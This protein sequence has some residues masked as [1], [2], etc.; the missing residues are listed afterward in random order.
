MPPYG[1]RV[2]GKPAIQEANTNSFSD[3]TNIKFNWLGE[4]RIVAIG[5]MAYEHGTMRITSD[6]KGY[7]QHHAFSAVM[8]NDKAKG[9]VCSE[10]A[11][12][13]HPLEGSSE[14]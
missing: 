14:P 11:G 5:D 9:A 1:K 3:R 10:V 12:T 2:T 13:M 8:L 6:T 7:G 4:H